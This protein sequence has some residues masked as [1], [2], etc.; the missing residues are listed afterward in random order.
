V[1][2]LHR[3]LQGEGHPVVLL[4][5][6]GLDSRMFEHDMP[7]LEK[8]AAVLRYDRSGSGRSPPATG[9]VDRV[10]ELRTVSGEAFDGRPCVLV[11]S[12][13]GGQLAIDFALTHPALVAGLVLIGPGLS[14][15]RDSERRRAW[16]R[17][18]PRPGM[19][20]ARWQTGGSTILIFVHTGFRR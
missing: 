2:P 17:S 10:E 12:S 16:A 4:H 7:E 15:H 8:A 3:T 13:H 6:G 5:A 19:E 9:P 18:P 11:G 1:A 14:G 20:A